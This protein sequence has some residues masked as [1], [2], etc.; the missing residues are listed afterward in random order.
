MIPA[1]S[2][3]TRGDVDTEPPRLLA[4]AVDPQRSLNHNQTGV[5]QVESGGDLGPGDWGKADE[6]PRGLSS[7]A[8]DHSPRRYGRSRTD[9]M[10]FSE[11][12]NV[13]EELAKGE[14]K[15]TEG[16]Q[17]GQGHS[18][19]KAEL[20]I[21]T[22]T[23]VPVVDEVAAAADL[24]ANHEW[25]TVVELDDPW[26]DIPDATEF[27]PESTVHDSNVDVAEPSSH[28]SSSDTPIP[29]NSIAEQPAIPAPTGST[30]S[31]STESSASEAITENASPQ[32]S[33]TEEAP[34]V[35]TDRTPD[36]IPTASTADLAS[37][38]EVSVIS[39]A[40]PVEVKVHASSESSSM[41]ADA[42]GGEVPA[43]PTSNPGASP[44]TDS[45]ASEDTKLQ[46]DI[47]SS[48]SDGSD[49]P[50]EKAADIPLEGSPEAVAESGL[51][52]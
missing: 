27:Q 4:A 44:A 39:D 34:K 6:N 21:E 1:S 29:E 36:E 3:G 10:V 2:E 26:A 20:E 7:P 43:P 52:S 45:I 35:E 50:V 14:K 5:P 47:E 9:T 25:D 23:P 13:A 19:G 41:A 15:E 30:T 22:I 31:T 11:A 8:R 33:I 38:A 16:T 40:P 42:D 46:T 37:E 17:S 12:F 24:E 49:S 18:A 48:A 32:Q 28:A 51:S